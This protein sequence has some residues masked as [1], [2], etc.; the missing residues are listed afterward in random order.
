MS[1]HHDELPILI[2]KLENKT[3]NLAI[4]DPWFGK[5]ETFKAYRIEKSQPIEPKPR[6]T[7]NTRSGG[8]VFCVAGNKKQKIQCH[9]L[10]D[11]N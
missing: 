7:C 11:C 2:N 4:T 3:D 9:I 5:F 6:L 10:N 1:F 8:V